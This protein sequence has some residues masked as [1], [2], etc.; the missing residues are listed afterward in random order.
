MIINYATKRENRIIL[1]FA[2]GLSYSQ[3]FMLV[4][5]HS[6]QHISLCIINEIFYN[7]LLIDECVNFI[8]KG[9]QTVSVLRF[10]ISGNG[11]QAFFYYLSI[12]FIQHNIS[13]ETAENF[14][15][16]SLF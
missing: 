13:S 2:S 16:I 10:N 12:F 15:L 3:I 9:D 1:L 7:A 4:I 11:F 5:I 14:I 6:F 8:L